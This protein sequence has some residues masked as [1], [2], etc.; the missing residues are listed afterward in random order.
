[1]AC[2]AHVA[3]T[4]QSSN[5]HSLLSLPAKP[6]PRCRMHGSCSALSLDARGLRRRVV[7]AALPLFSDWHG[8]YPSA[9]LSTIAPEHKRPALRYRVDSL[10]PLP[11]SCVR[12]SPSVLATMTG[13]R[14]SRPCSAPRRI[15][16]RASTLAMTSILAPTP[17]HL[18][19]SC[20]RVAAPTVGDSTT[21]Q[22]PSAPLHSSA[23]VPVP[24][25]ILSPTRY[26][27]RSEAGPLRDCTGP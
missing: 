2:A 24:P 11:T 1:M 14:S 27:Q 20:H 9:E 3:P 5:T 16:I 8:S 7:P 4:A 6:S 18:S 26:R 23:R 10:L 19:R 13:Q 17:P 15:A 12:K 25:E 22:Y 21:S